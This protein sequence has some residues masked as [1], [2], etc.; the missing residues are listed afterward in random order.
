[1]WEGGD[2][3]NVHLTMGHLAKDYNE[4]EKKMLKTEKESAGIMLFGVDGVQ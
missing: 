4:I 1:M 2:W 3:L